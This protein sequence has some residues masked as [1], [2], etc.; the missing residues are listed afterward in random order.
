[1]V[2]LAELGPFVKMTSSNGKEIPRYWPF[3]REIHRSPVNS[4]H[5]GPWHDALCFLWS[6]W[7]NGWANNREAGNLRRYRTH[8]DVTVMVMEQD[9]DYIRD[10]PNPSVSWSVTLTAMFW[11][12][13]QYKTLNF[14]G[15]EIM[16][17]FRSIQPQL[18]SRSGI[19]LRKKDVTQP[20]SFTLSVIPGHVDAN[21]SSHHN[22]PGILAQTDVK[23]CYMWEDVLRV[24]V[25]HGR[26][27]GTLFIP[28]SKC[29]IKSVPVSFTVH[30]MESP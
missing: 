13:F 27:R 21:H 22:K 7:I 18:G 9:G 25:R 6:A 26:V 24:P 16:G 3:V 12:F 19:R 28:Q 23:R 14:T 4:P 5:K 10:K 29:I 20:H 1:M 11:F 8:Y 30:K 15:V 17:L 2:V